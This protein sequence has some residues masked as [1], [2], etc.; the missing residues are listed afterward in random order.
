MKKHTVI[1]I[2][3]LF[4]VNLLAGTSASGQLDCAAK[5]LPQPA[6]SRHGHASG[7][8]VRLMHLNC[9]SGNAALPCELGS[10]QTT[11]KIECSFSTC[12]TKIPDSTHTA[13]ISRLILAEDFTASGIGLKSGKTALG[14]APPI[15]LQ[16]LSFIC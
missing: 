16:N 7:A 10:R 1:F 14:K 5:C 4:S 11:P 9:C 13:L 8:T 6:E 15:Y 3:L 2:A 12:R